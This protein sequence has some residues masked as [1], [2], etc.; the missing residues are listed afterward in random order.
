MKAENFRRFGKIAK[1]DYYLRHFSLS[2]CLPAC[3]SV[4]MEQLSFEWTGFHKI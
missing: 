3:P 2:V 4:R 1:S